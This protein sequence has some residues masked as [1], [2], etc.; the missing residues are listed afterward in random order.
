M[1]TSHGTGD[2]YQPGQFLSYQMIKRAV[3]WVRLRR[4]SAGYCLACT[5]VLPA[6]WKGS[7]V[8]SGVGVVCWISPPGWM[9]G[10]KGGCH[11]D[12]HASTILSCQV[13]LQII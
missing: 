12:I 2:E 9:S 5:V 8:E 11:V 10:F 1:T 13:S 4:P 6:P 3:Q 7:S